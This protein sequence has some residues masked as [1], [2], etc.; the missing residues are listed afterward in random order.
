MKWIASMLSWAAP[1]VGGAVNPMV[2]LA[3]AAVAAVVFGAGVTAGAVVNGWRLGVVVAEGEK[4]LS[5]AQTEVRICGGRLATQN[6]AIDAVADLGA[7][8]R[9]DI[10]VALSSIEKGATGQRQQLEELRG[11][12]ARSPPVRPDG[13]PAGCGDAWREIEARRVKS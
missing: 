2:L 8:I 13:K 10:D 12:I 6:T 7:G 11:L 1:G 5:I 9:K 4:A 3:I